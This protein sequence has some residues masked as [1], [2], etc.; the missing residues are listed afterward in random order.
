MNKEEIKETNADP[1]LEESAGELKCY[2][3]NI[4]TINKIR[5]YIWAKDMTEAEELIK[6]KK[7]DEITD[8][9]II[10]VEDIDNIENTDST[11]WH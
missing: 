6:E 7:F 3:F 1:Y 11:E 10:D 2:E 8:N 5:G 9:K 4:F